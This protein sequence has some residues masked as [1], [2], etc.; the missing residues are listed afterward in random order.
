MR[1]L[2]EG[3]KILNNFARAAA[4]EAKG[5]GNQGLT[6]PLDAK[7]KQ[8]FAVVAGTR[9]YD[10]RTVQDWL[11]DNTLARHRLTLVPLEDGRNTGVLL[12][13]L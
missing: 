10:G 2:L 5:K 6:L 9:L 8:P 13:P 1:D 11:K 12:T 4:K 3:K 7:R